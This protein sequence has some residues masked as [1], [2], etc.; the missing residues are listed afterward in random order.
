MRYFL[1]IAY[2][3][4]NYAGWQK[5]NNAPSVQAEIEKVLGIIL[6]ENISITGSGR[7]DTGVHASQQFAHFDCEKP[8]KMNIIKS[9]NAILPK[10]ISI[11]GLYEVAEQAHSRFDATQRKYQY[12][13]IRT[14][15]PFLDNFAAFIPHQL[16]VDLMQ[17]AAQKLLLHT[18]FE[19]FSKVK[20]NTKHFRCKISQANWFYSKDVFSQSD[21][22]VFEIAANRFLWG[23]VRAIVGTLLEVGRKK[24]HIEDF[25]EIILKRDRSL[26][27]GTAPPQGLYLSEVSYPYELGANLIAK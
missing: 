16:D 22:L 25:E 11:L 27:A 20:A 5:Q 10:D 1:E 23:M 4:T 26:A 21:I 8:V 2:Q 6:K 15:S 14:K 12:K 18:E 3:G 7:T 9:L 24:M 19:S 13:I 17:E